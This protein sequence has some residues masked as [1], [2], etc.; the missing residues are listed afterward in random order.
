MTV[1][2]STNIRAGSFLVSEANLT[3]SRTEGILKS[4]AKSLVGAVL[5]QVDAGAATAA[6]KA[7][8]ANTG[9]G[10]M[11]AVTVSAGSMPGVYR[12]RVTKAAANAGDFEVTDP[13]G[14]VVGVGSVAAAFAG[15][16]LGFTLADGSTDFAVGDG[17]D[18]TVAAG[19]NKYAPLNTAG[20]DGSETAVA[21]LWDTVDATSADQPCVVI[22]CDAEIKVPELVWPVGI[23]D[24]QKSTA[25][26]SLAS[27]GFKFS[28][29]Y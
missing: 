28:P 6:A 1:L 16:G 8:G 10:V 27:R 13:H 20:G 26:A 18:I 14:N 12:L 19:S 11:G 21:I 5:G 15:G 22:D 23:T 24:P 25:L 4:G 29:T 7:G 2:T 3:R 17:F 9:N